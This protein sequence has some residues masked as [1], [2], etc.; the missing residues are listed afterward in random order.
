MFVKITV[1]TDG[2]ETSF[3]LKG[4]EAE[5]LQAIAQYNGLTLAKQAGVF[6]LALLQYKVGKIQEGLSR[7]N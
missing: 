3:E 1:T 5:A 6:I 4:E 7:L 2:S